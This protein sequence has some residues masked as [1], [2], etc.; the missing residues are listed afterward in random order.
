MSTQGGVEAE[1]KQITRSIVHA[2]DFIRLKPEHHP[3][4]TRGGSVIR[5]PGSSPRRSVNISDTSGDLWLLIDHLRSWTSISRIKLPTSKKRCAKSD[6]DWLSRAVQDMARLGLI[7][8]SSHD[9]AHAEELAEGGRHSRS[10]RLMRWQDRLSARPGWEI[11]RGIESSS[12]CIIGLGGTGAT[13]ATILAG[14][15]IGSLQ[16]VDFDRVEISNL[17]RQTLYRESDVGG[18][19][20]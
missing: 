17:S 19:R 7:E 20:V 18:S 14:A 16:L 3:I 2:D 4:R 13:A 12:V 11:Q 1:M 5:F 8:C 10:I 6:T 15:G 9:P